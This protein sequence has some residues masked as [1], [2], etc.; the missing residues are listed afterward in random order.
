MTPDAKRNV[1][2]LL[3]LPLPSLTTNDVSAISQMCLSFIYI[4]TVTGNDDC[5]LLEP[6]NPWDATIG[7]EFPESDEITGLKCYILT[8]N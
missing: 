7:N 1:G 4:S 5:L 3:W 6:A 2:F 8:Q